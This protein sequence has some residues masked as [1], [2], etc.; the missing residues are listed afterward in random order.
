M[1]FDHRTFAAA[2]INM[3]VQRYLTIQE[4][5]GVYTLVR[6]KADKA[7]L[8]PEEKAVADKLFAGG[9]RIELRN[10]HHARVSLGIEALKTW[11]RLN[12][13]KHYFLT[14]RRYLIPGLVGSVLLHVAV[15]LSAPGEQKIIAGFLTVWLTGWSVG[16]FFLLS[17]VTQA[18][19]GVRAGGTGQRIFSAGGAMFLTLFS[20]PFVAG[21]IFGIVMLGAV[22]SVAVIVILLLVAGT[23]YLFHYLLKAPTRA[24]RAL[25]D[26]IEG[27]KMFLAATEQERRKVLYPPLRTPELFEKYLPYALALG[28]EQEWSEQFSEV[29][30]YAAQRGMTYA[31]AWYSGPGWRTLG[32]SGFASSLGSSFSGAISSS[33]SPP[34]SRSGGSG[35]GGGGSSGGGGGGG[36][37]GG[38]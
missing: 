15:A 25:L 12:L 33:S 20:L 29:L 23:N 5:D 27:F 16:V 4:N 22:T 36:G 34:G 37:G 10:T 1:G 8:S 31:P 7:R 13:E 11:L 30:A 18:W 38:W 9:D 26:Q 6:G 28:V 19:R 14:N 17:Q 24:G 3:A 21:E 2:V 35:G 32:A